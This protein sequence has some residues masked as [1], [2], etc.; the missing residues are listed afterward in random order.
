MMLHSEALELPKLAATLKEYEQYCKCQISWTK[1]EAQG[2]LTIF[3]F[4][5]L[6]YNIIH[7]YANSMA[8]DRFFKAAEFE[9]NLK[10]FNAFNGDDETP[11]D[12]ALRKFDLEGVENVLELVKNNFQLHLSTNALNKLLDNRAVYQ[13]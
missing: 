4:P 6:S 2:D 11:I 10:L 13:N 8:C 1:V 12:I 5:E 9:P 7:F 3:L